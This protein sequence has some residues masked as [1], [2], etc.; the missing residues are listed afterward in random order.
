MKQIKTTLLLALVLLA[1]CGSLSTV[2]VTEK[3]V[4]VRVECR[5]ES[6]VSNYVLQQLRAPNARDLTSTVDGAFLTIEVVFVNVTR[7]GFSKIEEIEKRLKEYPG[8][9]TVEVRDPI[10]EVKQVF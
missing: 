8:V 3:P 9:I 6:Y 5:N 4:Y 7:P 2:P 1:G 10:R